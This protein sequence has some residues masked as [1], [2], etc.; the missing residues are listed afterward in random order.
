MDALNTYTK[1]EQSENKNKTDKCFFFRYPLY[2][3]YSI[4]SEK[5]NVLNS[6][7]SAVLS[8]SVFTLQ[9][10]IN[11][12]KINALISLYAAENERQISYINLLFIHI[13]G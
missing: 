12:E 5:I 7:I 9:N 3:L 10:W 4:G 1:R 6:L 8:Q 11:W 2:R 13:F